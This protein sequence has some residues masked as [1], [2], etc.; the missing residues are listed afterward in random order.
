[1]VPL[2]S[3]VW[4][5]SPEHSV[6]YHSLYFYKAAVLFGND[7]KSHNYIH[8]G[9]KEMLQ[10]A[11][12]SETSASSELPCITTQKT[13]PLKLRADQI[14]EM[15]VAIEFR[16][17]AHGEALI[18]ATLQQSAIPTLMLSRSRMLQPCHSPQL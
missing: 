1:V 2:L 9:F 11:C 13:V 6:S 10:A 15:L 12:S 5:K 18:W 17:T 4:L 7:N 8:K 16:Q 14:Q 3:H